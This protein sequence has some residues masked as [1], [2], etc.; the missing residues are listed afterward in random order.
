MY[1]CQ[2]STKPSHQSV[3][4][5]GITPNLP[6]VHSINY[7]FSMTWYEIVMQDFLMVYQRISPLSLVVSLHTHSPKGSCVYEE[8]TSDSWN[9]P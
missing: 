8:N 2:Y 5:N 6:I 4:F 3:Q 7:V 9:I 1:I